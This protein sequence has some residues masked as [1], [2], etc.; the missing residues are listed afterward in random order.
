MEYNKIIISRFLIIHVKY[1]L[2]ITSMIKTGDNQKQSNGLKD[3]QIFFCSTVQLVF[4]NSKRSKLVIFQKGKKKKIE[5][6]TNDYILSI[7][8]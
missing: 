3:I 7:T 1:M 8:V 4:G 5:P 6:A 2:N